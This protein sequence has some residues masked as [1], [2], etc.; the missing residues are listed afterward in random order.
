VAMDSTQSSSSPKDVLHLRVISPQPEIAELVFNDLPVSTTVEQLK[1][2]IKDT[3]ATQPVP[4]SQRLIYQGR[5]MTTDSSTMTDVFGH[6]TV[7]GND[8]STWD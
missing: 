8:A 5:V 6:H 7:S 3:V 1:L 4:E 2:K